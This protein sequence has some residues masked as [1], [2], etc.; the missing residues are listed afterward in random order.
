ML[1]IFNIYIVLFW[2]YTWLYVISFLMYILLIILVY[3][4]LNIAIFILWYCDRFRVVIYI[5]HNCVLPYL[6]S[7]IVWKNTS[8]TL[9][10]RVPAGDTVPNVGIYIRAH[11]CDLRRHGMFW[12]WKLSRVSRYIRDEFKVTIFLLVS[13]LKLHDIKYLRFAYPASPFQLIYDN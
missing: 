7:V 12:F 5:S 13:F 3:T 2:Y 10:L 4:F 11:Q 9:V 1:L 6:F 8:H